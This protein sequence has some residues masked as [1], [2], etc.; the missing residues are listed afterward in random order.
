MVLPYTKN[1]P[2]WLSFFLLLLSFNIKAT[3]MYI[4]SQTGIELPKIIG[5][6]KLGDITP[7]KGNPDETGV[8]LPYHSENM[9]ATIFIKSFGSHSLKTA[10]ALIEESLAVVKELEKAGTYKDVKIYESNGAEDKPGWKRA[11]FTAHM[12]KAFVMSF[13][14]CTVKDGYAIKLRFTCQKL[15]NDEL[16][17][18]VKTLQDQVDKAHKRP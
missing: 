10:P 13:I 14:Y 15:K 4:H 16:T 17:T 6:F 9:E 12:D 7:Y 18:F 2:K 5:T 1:M 8:A 3:D 11:A